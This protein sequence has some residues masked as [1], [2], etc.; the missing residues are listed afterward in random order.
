ME[1]ILLC[2]FAACVIRNHAPLPGCATMLLPAEMC[3]LSTPCHAAVLLG[4]DKHASPQEVL[5]ALGERLAAAGAEA[6]VLASDVDE[7]QDTA[8]MREM[9]RYAHTALRRRQP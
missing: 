9:L 3:C 1:Q 8:T 7:M 6:A 2:C 5:A 4:C